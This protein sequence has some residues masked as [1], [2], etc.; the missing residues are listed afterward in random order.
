MFKVH[1]VKAKHILTKTGIPGADFVI[2]N[3]SG[4]QHGCI[5]CYA[6][7]ICRWRKSSEKWGEFVDVRTNAAELVTK[8]SKNKKGIVLLSSVSD[9]YQPVERK[10]KLTRRI[11]QNLNP[12]MTLSILTKSNLI[13]RDIDVL[14]RFKKHELGFTIT[15]LNPDIK[16]IFEPNSSTSQE[17]I[18]AL[19][20]LK[21]NG[22]YTYCFVAPILPFLT[23]LEEIVKEVFPFV[24]FIM[25]DWLNMPAA[26]GQIMNTIRDNFPELENKYEKLSKEFWVEKQK[27]IVQLGKKYKKPVKICFGSVGLLK[28]K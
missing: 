3:Y 11:L 4:C 22:F 14:T 23:D 27:E 20:K 24:D 7:F 19:Q 5:Y 26:R 16:K 17:R 13:I 10:Y 15:T 1:E 12:E 6:R 8:E 28:F 18:N 9:P 25:F 2:N 21:E